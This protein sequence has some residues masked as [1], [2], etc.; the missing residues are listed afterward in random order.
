MKWNKLL[1]FKFVWATLG[2]RLQGF[3]CIHSF[4]YFVLIR[5]RPSVSGGNRGENGI[6]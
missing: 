5:E 2:S 3:S 6:I 1:A 4:A